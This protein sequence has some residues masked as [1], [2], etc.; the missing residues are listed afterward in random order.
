MT[1][2]M[3]K[4]KNRATRRHHNARLL[5][6]AKNISRVWVSRAS[7]EAKSVSTPWVEKCARRIRDN[8]KPCS[9]WMCG[10]PRKLGELTVQELRAGAAVAE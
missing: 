3:Y 5:E 1:E 8:R 2:I 7:T 9:C 6:R 10:N 4:K